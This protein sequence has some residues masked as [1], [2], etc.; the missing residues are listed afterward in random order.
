MQILTQQIIIWKQTFLS[1]TQPSPIDLLIW[2][3]L[4]HLSSQSLQ[5]LQKIGRVS[6]GRVRGKRW[7]LLV[8]VVLIHIRLLVPS[9]VLL[10]APLC[11]QRLPRETARGELHL[12]N[13]PGHACALLLWI[14][15][16]HQLCDQ[17][18]GFLGLQVANLLG[19]VDERVNL[20]VMALLGAVLHDAARPTHL[21]WQLLTACVSHK[22]TWALLQVPERETDKWR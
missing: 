17:A 16:R 14:Q 1:V 7:R 11:P 5:L 20:L 10:Q 22:L 8:A 9:L 18:A 19:D 15:A 6:I 2:V 21:H 3:S 12:T 13:L 4:P